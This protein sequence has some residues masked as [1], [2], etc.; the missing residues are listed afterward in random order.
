M[1]LYHQVLQ[2]EEQVKTFVRNSLKLTRVKEMP[3]SPLL[4]Q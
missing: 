1:E 2:L 4:Q 3:Y